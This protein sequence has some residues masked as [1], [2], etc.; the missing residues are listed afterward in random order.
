MRTDFAFTVAVEC[1]VVKNL[2][3]DYSTST[4]ACCVAYNLPY[5]NDKIALFQEV[6]SLKNS[7][8]IH[9]YSLKALVKISDSRDKVKFRL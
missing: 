4:H 8:Y 2:S 3:K 5:H 9:L 1:V 6:Q 7:Y